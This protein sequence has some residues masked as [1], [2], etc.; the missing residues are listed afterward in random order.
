[1]F[2]KGDRVRHEE[3]GLGTIKSEY[4]G[5]M[6]WVYFDVWM[7]G[8]GDEGNGI[9]RGHGKSCYVK[10]LELVEQ[11][12]TDLTPDQIKVL[13]KIVERGN[14]ADVPCEDDSCILHKMHCDCDC[15]VR[16]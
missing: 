16:S 13:E 6:E 5:G 8:W 1:M 12:Q 15:D 4:D 10:D 7:D 9:P 3:Y 2:K 14:C 11:K